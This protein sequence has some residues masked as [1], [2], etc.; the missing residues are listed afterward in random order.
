MARFN[1][2]GGVIP[3]SQPPDQY[4]IRYYYDVH[5]V[6][7]DGQERHWFNVK[8]VYDKPNEKYIRFANE[9]NVFVQVNRDLTRYI[10][11]KRL[12]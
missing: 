2:I 10:S 4:V 9:D 1:P 8:D 7:A 11:I 3:T 6:F 5:V 12:S